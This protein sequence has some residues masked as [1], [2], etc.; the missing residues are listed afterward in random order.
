MAITIATTISLPDSAMLKPIWK[1]VLTVVVYGY[2]C[3]KT[4]ATIKQKL[5]VFQSKCL[6]L[7]RI[8]N[9]TWHNIISNEN[10]GQIPSMTKHF[11]NVA[12]DG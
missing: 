11:E 1:N 5:E 6:C 2:E 12:D 8:L 10:Q 3:W 4:T 7:R 9:I